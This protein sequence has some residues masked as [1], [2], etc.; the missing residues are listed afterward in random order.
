MTNY[1]LWN[2]F[3]GVIT[4][5]ALN[6]E[7]HIKTQFENI[8]NHSTKSDISLMVIHMQEHFTS[9]VRMKHTYIVVSEKLSLRQRVRKIKEQNN[10]DGSPFTIV[11]LLVNYV[12]ATV[13]HM[14]LW[15]HNISFNIDLWLV[16]HGAKIILISL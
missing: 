13:L 1:H 6:Y 14:P 3:L 10:L 5:N 16:N 8:F 9:V 12:S 7:M 15:T 2:G 11:F 4:Y